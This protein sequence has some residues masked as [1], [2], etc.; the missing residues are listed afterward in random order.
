MQN[1]RSYS[2]RITKNHEDNLTKQLALEKID[3]RL[4]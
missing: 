4:K 2:T 3:R 1:H